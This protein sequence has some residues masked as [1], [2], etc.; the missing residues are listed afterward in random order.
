MAKSGKVYI[1]TNKAMPGLCKIGMTT[2]LRQRLDSLFN[3]SVPYPF[4]VKYEID[5]AD[6]RATE[7]AIFRELEDCRVNPRRE[8]FRVSVS[9]AI[10]VAERCTTGEYRGAGWGWLWLLAIVLTV[11][12]YLFGQ[13]PAL[14]PDFFTEGIS[15]LM[16]VGGKMLS[17]Q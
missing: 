1:L 9:D 14:V 12:A 5:V 3:T 7:S 10:K 13:H 16:G 8:F 15:W 17:A 11:S 6:R 4:K 2:K